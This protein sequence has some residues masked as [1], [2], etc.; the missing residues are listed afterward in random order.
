MNFNWNSFVDE[1]T[2]VPAANKAAFS[3]AYVTSLKKCRNTDLMDG[4]RGSK[5]GAISNASKSRIC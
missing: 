5:A 1:L 3:P 2:T 4:W